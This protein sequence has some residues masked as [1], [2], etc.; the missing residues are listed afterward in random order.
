MSEKY[1]NLLYKN[2]DLL[3]I[4]IHIFLLINT[5]WYMLCIKNKFS[6]CKIFTSKKMAK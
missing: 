2:F 3:Y 5:Y 1:F 6:F 4:F